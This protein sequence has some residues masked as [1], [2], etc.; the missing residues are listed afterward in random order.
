MC[1]QITYEPHEPYA[2]CSLLLAS[3]LFYLAVVKLVHSNPIM[4]LASLYL[5]TFQLLYS[6]YL[7]HGVLQFHL[8]TSI[9]NLLVFSYFISCLTVIDME[10]VLDSSSSKKSGK[11]SIV[12]KV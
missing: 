2:T 8:T 7:Y 1:N 11:R 6:L 12:I 4:L 9:N 10:L 3:P 5:F